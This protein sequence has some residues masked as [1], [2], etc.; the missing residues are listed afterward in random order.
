M[1]IG[2]PRE[3]KIVLEGEEGGGGGKVFQEECIHCYQVS[4]SFTCSYVQGVA[5]CDWL[6]IHSTVQPTSP[7]SG[8]PYIWS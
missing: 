3:G 5:S 1:H 7:T 4:A 2:R 6:A 8:L